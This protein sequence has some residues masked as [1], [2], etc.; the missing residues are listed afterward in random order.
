MLVKEEYYILSEE[1]IFIMETS[2]NFSRQK[3]NK[4]NSHFLENIFYAFWLRNMFLCKNINF[5]LN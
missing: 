1:L 2:W 5:M 4:Y 3:E